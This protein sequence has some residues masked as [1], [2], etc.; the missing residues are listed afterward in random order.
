MDSMGNT[1]LCENQK[2]L[3]TTPLHRMEVKLK[4]HHWNPSKSSQTV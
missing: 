2:G 4:A 1:I 3:V